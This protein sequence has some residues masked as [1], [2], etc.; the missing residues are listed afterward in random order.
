MHGRV[1][2]LTLVAG[3]SMGIAQ[4]PPAMQWFADLALRK[5]LLNYSQVAASIPSEVK[6]AELAAA[7]EYNQA[8]LDGRIGLTDEATDTAYQETLIIDNNATIA[9]V[10]IPAIDVMLPVMHGTT[11]DILDLGAGHYYG[12]SL[13]VGGI[14]THTAISAHSGLVSKE[15]FTRLPELMIGSEFTISSVAGDLRYKVTDISKVTAD[16]AFDAIY[17]DPNRDLATLIT[18]VPIGI[19]THRLLV[20]GERMPD[21]PGQGIL[22]TNSVLSFWRFPGFPWWGAWESA[23]IVGVGTL[24]NKVLAPRWRRQ[25]AAARKARQRAYRNPVVE[26]V[27]TT[28]QTTPATAPYQP[29]PALCYLTPRNRSTIPRGPRVSGRRM[30][31]GSTIQSNPTRVGQSL[32]GR[33]IRIPG[34][35]S[36]V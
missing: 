29:D 28:Q 4:T 14:G 35:N 9:T 6:A 13:P 1:V 5:D 25:D 31:M 16:E 18:C 11:D 27:E 21:V 24:G 30:T 12:S 36:V 17:I 7:R 2:T 22:P 20:T 32:N 34:A 19:N 8:L 10:T 33:A 3:L 15:F 23:A 26:L